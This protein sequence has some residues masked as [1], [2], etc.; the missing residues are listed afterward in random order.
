[1]I[2]GGGG[3]AIKVASE[4][5]APLTASALRTGLASAIYLPL[6]VLRPGGR[7]RP[8]PGVRDLPIFVL[9]ALFGFFL[10][11]V[12]YFEGLQ[13]TTAVHGAL[14]WS[15]NP[16]ATAVA[17]A[18]FLRESPRPMTVYRGRGAGAGACAGSGADHQWR[19]V[20]E[21]AHAKG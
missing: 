21:L 8:Q 15:S 2:W 11:N 16:V 17:A 10:F 20:G 9:L 4:G 12:F 3:V 19:V 13:R 6:L 18:L 7:E 5:F 1:M 14:I